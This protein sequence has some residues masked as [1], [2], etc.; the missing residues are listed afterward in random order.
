LPLAKNRR[1]N[2][3]APPCCHQGAAEAAC[4]RGN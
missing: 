2:A 1:S 3:S 4:T